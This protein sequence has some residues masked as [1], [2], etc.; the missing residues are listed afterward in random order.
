MARMCDDFDLAAEPKDAFVSFEEATRYLE[1][2]CVR[3]KV[4]QLSYTLVHFI[5][6]TP[7]QVSW[8]ATYDPAY[9]SHY[10][11]HYSHF[12]DP[13]FEIAFAEN[14]IVDWA[15][16][17]SS[18]SMWQELLPVATR[19]GITKYGVSFPLKDGNFGNVLFSVNVKSNDEEWKSLR[20]RLVERFRPFAVYFHGRVKP[21]IQSREVAEINFTA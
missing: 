21:L 16:L 2:A 6:G 4:N 14:S 17:L 5:D 13:T 18:D 8:I 19:Y 20:D 1:Q 10:L 12:G 9:M 7:D 3:R 15:A 11:E